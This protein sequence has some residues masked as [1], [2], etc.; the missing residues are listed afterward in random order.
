LHYVPLNAINSANAAAAFRW[1]SLSVGFKS[2]E[3][4]NGTE[5]IG[6][7]RLKEVIMKS[8]VFWD[9][10]PCRHCESRHMWGMRRLHIQG[11]KNPQATR[12]V[13]VG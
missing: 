13:A 4:E 12:N 6:F 10:A 3:P 7:E 8:V 5:V 11:T 9:V 1:N 2:F